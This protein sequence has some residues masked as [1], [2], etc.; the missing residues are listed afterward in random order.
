M[1][2]E[3]YKKLTLKTWLKNESNSKSK[4]ID[5]ENHAFYYFYVA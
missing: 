2:P 5:I 4:E 1:I 3:D